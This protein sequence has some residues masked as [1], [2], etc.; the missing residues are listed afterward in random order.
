MA[1]SLAFTAALTF[2]RFLGAF[3]VTG[4]PFTLAHLA[5]VAATMA[6][7]PAA[8]NRLLPFFGSLGDVGAVPLILAHL[9]LAP[10]AILARAAGDMRRFFGTLT[11]DVEGIAPSPAIESIWPCSFSI[12]S[13][14]DI[15]RWS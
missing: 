15:I 1:A 4:A 2:L 10:A 11:A 6:A 12:C 8:L 5:L 7:L 13:L 14:M 9:A 3:G